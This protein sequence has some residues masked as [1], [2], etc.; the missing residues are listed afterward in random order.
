M[1]NEIYF[2]SMTY[3]DGLLKKTCYLGLTM[4]NSGSKELKLLIREK[5]M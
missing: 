2:R 1:K 5:V 3:I 4:Y